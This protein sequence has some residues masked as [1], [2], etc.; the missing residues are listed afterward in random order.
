M[1]FNQVEKMNDKLQNKQIKKASTGGKMD[2]RKKLGL[3]KVD[4]NLR[5][6]QMRC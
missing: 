4:Q 5:Q 2:E 1:W 3:D 6:E